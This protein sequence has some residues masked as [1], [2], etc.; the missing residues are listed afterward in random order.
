MDAENVSPDV[1]AA[2]AALDRFERRRIRRET[3][4]ALMAGMLASGSGS[5]SSLGKHLLAELAVEH[6]DALLAEL[7]KE[8]QDAE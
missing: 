7:E 4:T 8:K 1:K 3:A 6:T 2:I 5:W